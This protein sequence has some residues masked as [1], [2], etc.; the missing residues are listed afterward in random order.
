MVSLCNNYSRKQKWFPLCVGTWNHLLPEV[1]KYFVSDGSLNEE[2]QQEIE[3]LSEGRFIEIEQFKDGLEETLEKYPAI[4]AQRK[5]CVFYKR[6]IDFSIYFEEYDY[7]LSVDTDIGVLAPVELP[8]NLPDFAFCVDDVPGYSGDPKIVLREKIVT[9]LNAGFLLFQPKAIDFDFIEY[10]TKHYIS[11]GKTH[12]WAEQTCWALIA[13]NLSQNTAVFSSNSVAIISG[14]QKRTLQQIRSNQTS[15]FRA[16]QKINDIQSI[17]DIIG[18]AKIIH[19][20]GPGKPWIQPIMEKHSID[21]ST[22]KPEMI[23][24]D[25]LPSFS[26][27]QKSLMFLRLLSQQF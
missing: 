11:K 21:S 10:I 25:P 16:S 14:L 22:L 13:A 12:W 24:F 7:I 23:Q 26:L 9:G 2:Q 15:Y 6:I 8:P 18:N 1:K 17:Q 4:A 20:A 27:R 3:S 5:L 19:F